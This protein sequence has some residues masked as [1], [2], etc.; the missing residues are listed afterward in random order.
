MPSTI[1]FPVIIN[2]LCE[3]VNMSISTTKCPVIWKKALVKPLHKSG[4]TD[5]VNNY[6]P[7]SILCVASKLLEF[8]V[9]KCLNR[10]ICDKDI[11]CSNQSGFRRNHSCLTCLTMVESWYL[12]INEGNI[13]GSVELD[14]CKAFDTWDHEILLNKLKL[15]GCDSR[16]LSWLRSYLSGRYQIVKIDDVISSSANIGYGIPQGS[17]LS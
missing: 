14:F 17:G 9:H 4:P 12:A 6:R 8:H 2:T 10:Y 5:L 7:I 11:L 16:S 15:Y 13:V 1:C 3:I